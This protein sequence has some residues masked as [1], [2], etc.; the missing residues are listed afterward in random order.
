M[1]QSVCYP[2]KADEKVQQM[3]NKIIVP[4][5]YTIANTNSGI[6]KLILEKLVSMTYE[7]LTSD[8]SEYDLHN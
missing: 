2:L 6:R 5:R 1:C 7:L 4:A 3:K 8:P